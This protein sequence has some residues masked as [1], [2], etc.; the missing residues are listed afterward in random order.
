[1]TPPSPRADELAPPVAWSWGQAGLGLVYALPAVL[2]APHDPLAGLAVAVGVIPATLVPLRP[3]R[4]ERVFVLLVGLV[5]GFSI[6]LGSLVAGTPALAVVSIFALAVATAVASSSPA[7]RLAPMS[8]T[9]GLPLV[10]AGLSESGPRDGLV[11]AGLIMAGSSYAWAVSLLW[12]SRPAGSRPRRTPPPRAVALRYGVQ[13]GSAAAAAAALGF[14]SG[15]DHPGWP[16]IAALLVSRPDTDALH[17]RATGRAVSVLAGSLVACGL[18][19]V[20]PSNALIGA[21][22]AVTLACAAATLGSRWYV[23]PA[24]TTTLVLSLLLADGGQSSSYWFLERTGQT[25]VGIAL[26]LLASWVARQSVR[27]RASAG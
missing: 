17:A 13:I 9:L 5:A 21:L 14:A 1:M 6:F 3:A 20:H 18:A 15:L 12:P 16:V 27:P 8:L 23:T 4:R 7:R 11:A 26:A 2:V 19:A 10:G 24:F 25:L 22:A